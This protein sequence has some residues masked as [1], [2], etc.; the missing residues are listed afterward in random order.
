MKRALLALFLGLIVGNI[1]LGQSV[2]SLGMG[3]LV[4]PGPEASYLNPAYAAFPAN[5]YGSSADF[6]LP[7]GL[8]ALLLNPQTSPFGNIGSASSP[9][10]L[11]SAYDQFTHP[12]EFL[13]NPASSN[14]FINPATGNP[15][16]VINVDQSGVRVTDSQGRPINLNFSV[17]SP[18]GVSSNKALTPEPF[19]RLPI[20]LGLGLSADIGVFAGGVGLGLSPNAN[21]QQAVASQTLQPNTDYSLSAKAS[22]QAGV[23]LGLSYAWVLPRVPLLEST[24]TNVYVGGRGEGFYGLAYLEGTG[25]ARIH[26]DNNSQPSSAAYSGKMFFTTPD[27]GSGIGLRADLGV[28]LEGQGSTVGLGLRNV[29]GFARWTGTEVSIDESGQVTYQASDRSSFGVAPAIFLNAATKVALEVGSV[30]V[31]GDL[32]LEGSLYTHLGGEYQLGELRLRAGLGYNGG[33]MLGLGAG[34]AGAGFSFDAAL[35]THQAPIVGGTVFGL[36]IGLGV[37]Y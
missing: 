12:N 19:F 5:M 13:I 3:G 24:V 11:L 14:A 29:L 21:L 31:G 4:L 30:I 15:E 36:A 33:F 2:R 20:P 17:G 7:V 32:G 27:N 18:S 10:D 35:T 8:V 25:T 26:T 6:P 23:S 22:A 37:S 34:Y 28:A 16:I 1:A 9:F